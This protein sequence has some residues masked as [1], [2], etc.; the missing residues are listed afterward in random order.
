MKKFQEVSFYQAS[1]LDFFFIFLYS[2][3]NAISRDSSCTFY[4]YR[5]LTVL[6]HSNGTQ[7]WCCNTSSKYDNF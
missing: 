1:A 5:Q 7:T 2:H 3:F 6:V 4:K